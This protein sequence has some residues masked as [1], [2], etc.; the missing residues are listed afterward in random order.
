MDKLQKLMKQLSDPTIMAFAIGLN[1]AMFLFFM[2]MSREDMMIITLGSALACYLSIL[3]NS[4]NE[5]NDGH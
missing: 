5:N 3:L 1:V 2:L 4:Q